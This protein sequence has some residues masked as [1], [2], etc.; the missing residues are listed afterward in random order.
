VPKLHANPRFL[1]IDK[2]NDGQSIRV[3]SKKAE[4]THNFEDA[5]FNQ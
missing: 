5:D 2:K 4:I 3:Q 1:S